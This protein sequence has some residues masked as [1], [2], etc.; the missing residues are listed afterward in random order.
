MFSRKKKVKTMVNDENGSGDTAI[1]PPCSLIGH[2]DV[3]NLFLWKALL[4][5]T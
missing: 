5:I 4:V 1:G 3:L 2:F